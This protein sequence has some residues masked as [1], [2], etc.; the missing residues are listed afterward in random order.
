[1][2]AVSG[3][4]VAAF[5]AQAQAKRIEGVAT[6]VDGDTLDFA[7]AGERVRLYAIDS[8]ESEQTCE[9]GSGNRYLCGSDAAEHLAQLVGRSGRVTCI[10][11]ERDGYGRP[12]AECVT[13][14][15]TVLNAEM[16]K[17]G[18]AVVFRRFSDGRYDQEEAEAKAAKIGLWAGL[19]VQP[20]DWRKGDRLAG[21][22][23]AV[24]QPEERGTEASPLR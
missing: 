15:N 4:L 20:A 23:V 18:W 8:P 10:W 24:S 16:V 19:F 21:E 17:A 7:A 22:R 13:P 6:V 14:D 11:D 12:V 5:A 1:L 2:I 9:D 3:L